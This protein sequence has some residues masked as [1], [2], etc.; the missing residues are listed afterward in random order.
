M[1]AIISISISL[2][3][4]LTTVTTEAAEVKV[5]GKGGVTGSQ[6]GGTTTVKICPE[7]DPA[8]C[9][10]LNINLNEIKING[11]DGT[12]IIIP[13]DSIVSLNMPNCDEVQGDTI[14]ITSDGL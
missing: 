11:S 6:S 1:K 5:Y 3:F 12:I 14:E 4:I 8:V 10:T 2:L 7:R 13:I 9:A